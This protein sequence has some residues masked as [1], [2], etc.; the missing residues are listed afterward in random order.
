MSEPIDAPQ[1][2]QRLLPAGPVTSW[3]YEV[4]TMFE[5]RETWGTNA[6]F[7]PTEVEAD[8]AAR[9]LLSRWLLPHAYRTVERPGTPPNYSMEAG[10]D[11]PVETVFISDQLPVAELTPE[12]MKRWR[13]D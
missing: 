10:D 8:T 2:R 12:R 5:G 1:Q 4:A 6:L 9:E 13:I 3:Q 11:R 7:F